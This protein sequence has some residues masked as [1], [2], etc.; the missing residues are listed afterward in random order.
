MEYIRCVSAA[1]VTIWSI[2][3]VS[4]QLVSLYGVHSVCQCSWCHYMEYIRCVSAAGVTI[5]S[6]LFSII[7]YMKLP[8][9]MRVADGRAVTVGIS[10]TSNYETYCHDLKVMGSNPGWLHWG[11]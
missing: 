9:M 6:T 2:F 4:A 7:L 8:T 5:W 11:A 10:V 3:G 1:G